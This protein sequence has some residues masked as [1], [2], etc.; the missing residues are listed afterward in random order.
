MRLGIP[1]GG[2]AAKTVQPPAGTQ[3]TIIHLLI[4]CPQHDAIREDLQQ[5]LQMS[6]CRDSASIILGDDSTRDALKKFCVKVATKAIGRNKAS[7]Q[8]S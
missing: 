7:N 2:C 1:P 5:E 4:D 8:D 6:L 3:E